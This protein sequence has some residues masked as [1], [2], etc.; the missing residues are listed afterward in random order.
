MFLIIIPAVVN[1]IILLI[2]LI[3]ALKWP[4]LKT[5]AATNE[6]SVSILIPA[7]NE[8]HHIEGVLRSAIIQGPAVKE[9]LVYDDHSTDGTGAIVES[10]REE[11]PFIRLV[12]TEPLGEGWLGKP[13]ACA[14]LGAAA[15]GTWLLFLD[16]DT[17][18]HAGAVSVMQGE[19]E[20]RGITFLSCWPALLAGSFWE[21]LFMPMLNFASACM[22]GTIPPSTG[23]RVY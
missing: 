21:H 12:Q 19:A 6:P 23:S 18:L 5:A 15:S 4:T 1:L 7:R 2:V 14:Q 16:A 17:R 9:I 8:A 3:N 13:F 22:S 20:Q 11:A 10:M